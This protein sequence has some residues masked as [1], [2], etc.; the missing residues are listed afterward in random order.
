MEEITKEALLSRRAELER[1]QRQAV[2]T[3]NALSGAIQLVDE[4]LARL[5]GE[6]PVEVVEEEPDA[7]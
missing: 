3:V 4:L 7:D 2:A 5:D 6:E 1:D